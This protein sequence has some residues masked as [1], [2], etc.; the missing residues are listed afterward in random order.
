MERGIERGTERGM[1]RVIERGT[2]RG[3]ERGMERGMGRGTERG[4]ERGMERGRER[5][6][7]NVQFDDRKGVQKRKKRTEFVIKPMARMND[8]PR[9][10]GLKFAAEKYIAEKW[11]LFAKEG[12]SS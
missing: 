4:R 11:P 7:E 3:T 1:E 2:E 6:R 12:H 5:G 8:Y 10:N 9:S